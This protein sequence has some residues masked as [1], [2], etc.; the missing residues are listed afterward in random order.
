MAKYGGLGKLCFEE[1]GEE[2]NKDL[3]KIEYHAFPDKT[4][5]SGAAFV[6]KIGGI[7]EDDGWIVTYV[8]SEYTNVSQVI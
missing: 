6:S 7:E 5:C 3:I 1:L 4:F 8:H 2:T